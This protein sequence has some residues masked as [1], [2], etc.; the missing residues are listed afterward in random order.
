MSQRPNVEPAE[1]ATELARGVL[2]WFQSLGHAGLAE[3]PL[4]SGRRADV[5][6]LGRRGELAIVEIKRTVADFH[7]DRKWPEYL[8]DCDRFYFA[9]P[10]GFPRQILP[11][12]S[13][14]LVADRYGAGLL[15]PAPEPAGKLPPARRRQTLLRFA[16]LAAGRLNGLIDP[17]V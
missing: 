3:F 16:H 12:W 14:L 2:R 8:E 17:P 7:G 15:R 5:L 6:A 11:A 10:A 13:G 9:V 1:P 4:A